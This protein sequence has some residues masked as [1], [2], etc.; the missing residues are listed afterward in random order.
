MNLLSKF[1]SK[2]KKSLGR[3]IPNFSAG[4]TVKVRVKITEGNNSRIQ[5]FEG[6]VIRTKRGD[7]LTSSFMV[8]KVSNGEMVERNFL[9]YSPIIDGIEVVKRGKVR[10]AKIYYMR[11]RQGKAARIKEIK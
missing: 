10:R 5:N 2:Y 1:E 9:T 6:V 8:K 7:A 4:D 11:H 3:E